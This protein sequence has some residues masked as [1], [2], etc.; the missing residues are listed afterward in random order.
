MLECCRCSSAAREMSSSSLSRIVG[1]ASNTVIREPKRFHTAVPDDRAAGHPNTS[2]K[3]DGRRGA[4]WPHAGHGTQS[5]RHSVGWHRSSSRD[6]EQKALAID[7]GALGGGLY[8][9]SLPPTAP[10]TD[11]GPPS[12]ILLA[13]Y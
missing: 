13:G 11:T 9:V 10:N 7:D 12:A 1:A 4:R 8:S 6:V 5:R 3:C 2:R